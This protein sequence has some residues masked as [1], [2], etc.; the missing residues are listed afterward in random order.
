MEARPPSAPEMAAEGRPK[1]FFAS[2]RALPSRMAAA[3]VMPSPTV[4]AVPRGLESFRSGSS[5]GLA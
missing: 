3:T 2:A 5:T 1:S 4:V